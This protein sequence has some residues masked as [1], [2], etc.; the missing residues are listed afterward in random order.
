MSGIR[1][2]TESV[3]DEVG[4]VPPCELAPPLDM[5]AL[6]IP[7]LDIPPLDIPPLD[8][9]ALDMPPLDIDIDIDASPL[10]MAALLLLL[11]LELLDDED[12]SVEPVLVLAEQAVAINRLNAVAV[13][14]AVRTNCD[15]I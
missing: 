15:F 2:A 12:E 3:D 14:A 1:K 4:G 10:V 9:S 6:D 8:M 5:S 13:T 7:P 11:E